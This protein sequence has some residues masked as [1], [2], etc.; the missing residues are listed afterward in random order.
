M[1]GIEGVDVMGRPDAADKRRPRH[2]PQLGGKQRDVEIGPEPGDEEHHLRGD[3]QDHPV[4]VRDLHHAGVVVLDLG[5]VDHVPPPADHRVGD[6]DTAD[7]EDHRREGGDVVHPQNQPERGDE[8]RSGANGRPRAGIY[9]VV[10]VVRFGVRYV[11]HRYLLQLG[12]A[13]LPDR[14][15]FVASSF[16]V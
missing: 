16:F 7:A 15:A 5:F 2:V 6:A 12:A 10:V 14:D 3:E 4:A 9:Q 8:C 11:G 1:P 13:S